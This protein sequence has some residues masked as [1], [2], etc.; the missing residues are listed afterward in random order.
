MAI[1]KAIA[2]GITLVILYTSAMFAL[3]AVFLNQPDGVFWYSM[4]AMLS[5]V[6]LKLELKWF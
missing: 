1:L 6:L 2:L 3:W 4:S 5:G